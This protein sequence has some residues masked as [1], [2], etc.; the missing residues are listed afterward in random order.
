MLK[1][2]PE[3][4]TFASL[5][6]T[7]KSREGFGMGEMCQ[8]SATLGC[9][10]PTIF[11]PMYS[12]PGRTDSRK[13]FLWAPSENRVVSGGEAPSI[14]T[15]LYS[16][17]NPTLGRGKGA[18]VS[19]CLCFSLGL[20]VCQGPDLCI[21]QSL[22]VSLALSRSLLVPLYL[23]LP[24]TASDS[25]HPLGPRDEPGSGAYK[26]LML[27][28]GALRPLGE[29]ESYPFAP[30]PS[31]YLVKPQGGPGQHKLGPRS[32]PGSTGPPPLQAV[33]S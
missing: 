2:K 29:E 22:S 13:A 20:P 8:G 30:G 16:K 19:L 27:P 11:R 32:A 15:C 24:V 9:E 4:H 28:A 26:F 3:T 21:P 10:G 1:F 5:L 12:Q 6:G 23:N 33:L 17:A 31:C 14:Y 25:A 7:G 18:W